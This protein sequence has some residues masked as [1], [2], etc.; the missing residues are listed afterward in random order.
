MSSM[1]KKKGGPAFKPKIPAA[2]R[3]A[4][5]VPSQPPKPSPVSVPPPV[6]EVPETQPTTQESSASSSPNETVTAPIE[7]KPQDS[8]RND[9]QPPT[10]PSTEPEPAKPDDVAVTQEISQEKSPG[11]SQHGANTEDVSVH[12]EETAAPVATAK[13]QESATT[14][15]QP[16]SEQQDQSPGS[17][18]PSLPPNETQSSDIEAA[19]SPVLQTPT[20]DDSEGPSGTEPSTTPSHLTDGPDESQP[21]PSEEVQKATKSTRKPRARKQPTQAAQDEAGAEEGARPKKRQRKTTE[22]GTTPKQPRKRKAATESGTNTPKTRRARSMTPEDSETQLVDLQKLKMADLTKDLHIGKKFS[23]H[24]ELRERERRARMKNKIGTDVERDSSATPE[25]SGQVEKSGSPAA[26]PAPSAPAPAAPSGPQFRIVDGQIVIDQSSLSVDRHARAAAAA[27]DM[28]TVEENDFTRLITSNSFMNTSK[29]KGPN[30]WTEDETE[31]FY[32]GLCMFGTDFE[33][34]SKMFPGKQRRNV[35][36]KFNREE[37]HCPRRINAALIGEKTVKMNIDEYKAFTGSE[38]EPVE[39]IEAEQRKIQ[40]EYE[41]EE[42]R[43][44]DEQAEAMRKKREELFKDDEDGD[45]KKKKKKKK[46]TI[47]YGL[48]GEPIVQEE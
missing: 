17:E 40:E 23:R 21:K 46:Q 48:N 47:I 41:A 9:G 45:A 7:P 4:A 8:H 24:D 15:T 2:R 44:A 10:P 32:R 39:A 22:E 36:L 5:P 35:K 43:R 1:F 11:E 3:P 12:T 30:I 42:K 6:S 26:S 34:I 33:M 29:L 19:A 20:P 38:F 14:Q 37:R 25:T 31:L 28:E 13:A 16:T 18:E 27:G